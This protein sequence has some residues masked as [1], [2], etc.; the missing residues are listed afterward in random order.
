MS[1]TAGR[2]AGAIGL[3]TLLG[4]VYTYFVV[5]SVPW[6]A[7]GQALIG[8][9]LIG[10]YFASNYS[11]LGQFASSRSSFFMLS[12]ALMTVLVAG[13]LVAVNYIAAKRDKTW[14]LTNK[15]IYSLA[16]Q[17]VTTLQGLKEKVTAIGF[18]QTTHPAYDAL[19][20]LFERYHRE[21]PE[22]F[23]F[24]FKDPR[25][26]PDLALKYQVK[27]G[28]A[29][30]VVTRGEG[31]KE[32]HTAL[33]VV[34][35]QEL[36]NALIKINSV[37]EQKVYFVQGHGEWTLEENRD[38]NSDAPGSVSEFKK[39]LIQ[40]GYTPEA[41]TLLGK[42]DV[43]K[44]AALLVI[45]GSHH[46]FAA[47]EVT[48][49]QRYLDQGGRVL[50]FAEAQEEA[51][52]ASVLESYGVALDRG[53]VADDHFAV[54][55][56][57]QVLSQFYADHEITKLLKQLT[58]TVEFLPSRG[59]SVL[60]GGD[61]K[62]LAVVLTSPYGWVE[63]T[64]NENPERSDGEKT[65]QIPLVVASTKATAATA[66]AK[67]FDE[68]RLVVFGNSEILVDQNWGHEANR[69][70]IMNSVAWAT[71]QVTKITIRPP[72]RD[73]STIDLDRGMMGKIRFVATDLF[74]LSLLSLGLAIWISR[75]SK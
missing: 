72:D 51:G 5:L 12:A 18:V 58:L 22:K 30:V 47:P 25:K 17:T 36:T 31:A 53:I 23:E 69:N 10:V 33:N 1:S 35:E 48:L 29:T 62:P 49:L 52:I 60:H 19:Q 73:I 8:A 42:D 34:S 24:T 68:S 11:Q 57:Y 66:A 32:S 50:F 15:K 21:T 3:V 45:A 39:T 43:P 4:S 46:A 9:A 70:L 59:L 14:D 37:G 74:P 16:P 6:I 63:T 26:S 2:I 27:E 28:Q 67:R 64:P 40:E 54:N 55:S 56:P 7:G 13:A 38:P 61:A 41:L 65:G 71:Q 20:N 44:D 75:R